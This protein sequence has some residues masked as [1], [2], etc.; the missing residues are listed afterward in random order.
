M[1]LFKITWSTGAVEHVF[2]EAAED[3]E[4]FLNIHFGSAWES[5]KEAGVQVEHLIGEAA[6]DALE[7]LGLEPEQEETEWAGGTFEVIQPTEQEH[8]LTT[9]QVAALSATQ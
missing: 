4:S 6:A 1:S 7:M 8:V 3:L 5:A 9:D 2:Q